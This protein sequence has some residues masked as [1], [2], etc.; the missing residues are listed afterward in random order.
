MPAKTRATPAEF[1][2]LLKNIIEQAVSVKLDT[3]IQ[4]AQERWRLKSKRIELLQRLELYDQWCVQIY[5]GYCRFHREHPPVPVPPAAEEMTIDTG[6]LEK[7]LKEAFLKVAKRESRDPSIT[8]TIESWLNEQ[9]NVVRRPE[10][11]ASRSETASHI[12][13]AHHCSC[14][15]EIA[16]LQR[17]DEA[18]RFHQES[19]FSFDHGKNFHSSTL[20][21]EGSAS[22]ICR[23]HSRC[24][25]SG[26]FNRCNE[27]CQSGR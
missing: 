24:S 22:R 21:P 6:S 17:D 8:N 19:L 7:A 15:K 14:R 25:H 13:C 27:K 11:I 16:T 18:F 26:F 10:S 4:E 3:Q 20:S 12:S 1:D 23:F 9:E 5:H 2:L